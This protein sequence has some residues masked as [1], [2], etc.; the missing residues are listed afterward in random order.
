MPVAREDWRRGTAAS[1]AF[2]ILVILLILLLPGWLAR[3]VL[4]PLEI[5]EGAGGLDSRPG[6]GGGGTR[7]SGAYSEALQERVQYVR[8]EPPKPQTV[9]PVP[10]PVVQPVIPPPV[11]P[12][13]IEPPVPVPPPV[14]VDITP[15]AAPATTI[16]ATARGSGGGTGSDGSSGNGPGSGGGVGSGIGTGR[17]SGVGPGTGGG[18]GSVYPPSLIQVFLPPEAPAKL[19]PL[20]VVVLFDV[21]ESG[22]VLNINFTPT[23]DGGYNKKLRTLLEQVKFRPATT[24]DGRPIRAPFRMELSM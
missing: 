22:H 5:S 6:G 15:P 1:L 7:G 23:K 16:D 9:A 13:V 8:A 4:I 17:G 14:L 11:V 12:P 18:M 19:R 24:L 20:L 3:G 21:D 2:H 10:M